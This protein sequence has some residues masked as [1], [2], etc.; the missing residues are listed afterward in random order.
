VDASICIEDNEM[1]IRYARYLWILLMENNVMKQRIC[2]R[3]SDQDGHAVLRVPLSDDDA[4]EYAVVSLDDWNELM[5]LGMSPV[6]CRYNR[7][8]HVLVWMGAL[9]QHRHVARLIADAGANEGVWLKDGNG[10]NLRS[11]NLAKAPNTLAK[12]RDRD[13]LRPRNKWSP[14]I[15]VDET[16]KE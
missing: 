1:G 2:I 9:R 6:W 8:G 16:K 14:V 11:S 10:L 15:I 13:Y 3:T 7:S 4:P 5:K 12:H